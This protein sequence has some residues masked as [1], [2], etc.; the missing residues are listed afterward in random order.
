M[1]HPNH[2]LALNSHLSDQLSIIIR[3]KS[4]LGFCGSYLDVPGRKCWDQRLVDQWGFFTPI[5]HIYT[6][7]KQAI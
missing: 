7:V 4:H 2:P 5:Y 3:I 6:W 1:I